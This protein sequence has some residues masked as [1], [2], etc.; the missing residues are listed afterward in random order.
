MTTCCPEGG[1][2]GRY[3]AAPMTR[4]FPLA[5]LL[6]VPALTACRIDPGMAVDPVVQRPRISVTTE[7]TGHGTMQTET[8]LHWDPGSTLAFPGYWRVGLSERTEVYLGGNTF[9]WD[10]DRDVS[11]PGDLLIGWKHRLLDEEPGWPALA[12][13]TEVKLPTSEKEDRFGTEVIDWRVAL[14]AD[15]HWNATRVSGFAQ[16]GYLSEADGAGTD[17]E[18]TLAGSLQAPLSGRWSWYTEAL[19]RSVGQQNLRTTYVGAGLHYRLG[20]GSL[21]DVAA[22]AGFDDAPEDTLFVIGYTRNVGAFYRLR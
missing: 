17:L 6:W 21:I 8:G 19:S 16:L 1:D 12:F 10:F 11:G 14:I 3:R 15:T 4:S 2:A 20:S 22:I 7:T 18:L 13:Q 5:A 9:Q